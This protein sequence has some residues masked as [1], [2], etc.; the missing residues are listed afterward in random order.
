MKSYERTINKIMKVERCDRAT[1]EKFLALSKR[2]TS[3]DFTVEEGKLIY[4]EL[5]A[6]R[7]N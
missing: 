6:L 1:A 3:P 4:A 5:E 7:R 2:L